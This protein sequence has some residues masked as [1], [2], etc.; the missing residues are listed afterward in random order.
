MQ[1]LHGEALF[2]SGAFVLRH[3]AVTRLLQHLDSLREGHMP[4]DAAEIAAVLRLLDADAFEQQSSS[5]E[6][7]LHV[8]GSPV[9]VGHRTLHHDKAAA[10][11]EMSEN[12][13]AKPHSLEERA[14]NASDAG[15]VWLD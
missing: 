4:G 6:A 1:R 9:S 8:S 7:E 5:R 15:M 11:V 3:N 13:P 2:A 10:A 14:V 12:A